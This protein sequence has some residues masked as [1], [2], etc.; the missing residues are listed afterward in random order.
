MFVSI[1]LLSLLARFPLLYFPIQQPLELRPWP[2]RLRRRSILPSQPLWLE[3]ECPLMSVSFLTFLLAALPWWKLLGSQPC[4]KA[5]LLPFVVAR[6]VVEAALVFLLAAFFVL[7]L[8]ARDAVDF[9]EL[10]A[11]CSTSSQLI[12]YVPFCCHTLLRERPCSD[13]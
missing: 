12:L 11:P 9:F 4:W 1:C 7:F 5:R 10:N 6:F 2:R 13:G 8:A 3:K